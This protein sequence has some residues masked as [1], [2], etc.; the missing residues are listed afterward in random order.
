[1]ADLRLAGVQLLQLFQTEGAVPSLWICPLSVFQLQ[2]PMVFWR[3]WAQI[4]Q[5]YKDLI[6]APVE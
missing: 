5:I 4:V 2:G 6:L 1:M 3:W